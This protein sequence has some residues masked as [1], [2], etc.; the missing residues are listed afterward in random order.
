MIGTTNVPGLSYGQVAAEISAAES[1]LNS[2]IENSANSAS[3]IISIQLS[4]SGWTG[5]GPYTQTVTK[6]RSNNPLPYTSSDRPEV[7]FDRSV[8]PFANRELYA[9]ECGYIDTIETGNGT[10]T[11][12]A[13][14]PP[15]LN[16]YINLKGV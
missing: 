9:E 15:T 5:S 14:A 1:R 13:Y 12:S 7:Y 11:A 8:H 4:A 10:I 3:N 2:A 6:D 16:M